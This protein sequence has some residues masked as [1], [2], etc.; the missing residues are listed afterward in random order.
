[1]KENKKMKALMEK[2]KSKTDDEMKEFCQLFWPHFIEVDGYI[3]LAQEYKKAGK[4]DYERFFDEIEVESFV[5]HIHLQDYLDDDH[6]S[7]YEK[8]FI[9][10]RLLEIWP[11]KIKMEYPL[12]H[13]VFILTCDYEEVILR[14][15]KKRNGPSWLNE[16]RLDDYSEG[17]MMK[18]V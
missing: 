14:F 6:L 2:A 7:V 17:I 15:Y 5:N 9:G 13:F 11:C 3:F 8:L 16:D 4:L 1:M 10:M 18:E 12:S